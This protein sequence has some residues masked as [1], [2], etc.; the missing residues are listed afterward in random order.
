MSLDFPTSP[1]P[2]ICTLSEWDLPIVYT[3]ALK[4]QAFKE[5]L[6]V[7]SGRIDPNITDF[8]GHYIGA[9]GE[10]VVARQLGIDLDRAIYLGGDDGVDLE[11]YHGWTLQV[12]TIYHPTP[13]PHIAFNQL[14]DF[15]ASVCI[16]VKV[17]SPVTLAILGAISRQKFTAKHKPCNL[18]HG[19]RVGVLPDQLMALPEFMDTVCFRE[20]TS[21]KNPA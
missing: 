21:E 5:A 17:R 12:K 14:A 7:K 1:E 3:L 8:G 20:Q 9:M 2:V 15:K 16:A 11:K 19:D 18:K 4:R 10:F 6:G 13:T